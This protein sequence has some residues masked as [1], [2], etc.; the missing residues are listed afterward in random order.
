MDIIKD[1]KAR[2]ILKDVSNIE[3]FK[4][5]EKNSAI[6]IGFDPTATS[7]HLGNYIQIAILK[8]FESYGFKP[9]AILGGATG[10]IGDPSFKNAERKLLDEKAINLNK[11]KIKKQLEFF[12]LEVIDNY[13]WYKDMSI[14]DFLRNIGK[15]VNISYLLAKDSIKSRIEKGLSFTEFSYSLLQGY[16][17]LHLFRTKNIKIQFG[18]SDQW[19]NLT[20]GLE[21]IS[22]NVNKDHD[23]II[24]TGN[25]L[26][27]QNGNKI[28]KSQ[29]GGGLWIDKEMNPPFNLYQYF[30]NLDDAI[31]EKFYKWFSFKPL[32]E[33]DQIISEWKKASF[34]K[35]AQKMLAFEVVENIYSKNDAQKAVEITTALFENQEKLLDLSAKDIA[36]LTNSLPTYS[37]CQTSIKEVLLQN[38]I[39]SSNRELN[40][41]I[42]S[43]SISINSQKIT[44]SSNIINF[45]YDNKFALVKIGKRKYY[46]IKNEIS[47]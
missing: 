27:D 44:D 40:E 21:M 46:I 29:G 1:L 15:L 10:M 31:V 43:N 6:Y 34:K 33:I 45:Y 22:K 32:D 12:G 13:D 26:T 5:L 24:M 37:S 16:D 14:I 17:F 39:V 20:T 19:G 4:S 28:G 2:G 41:F 23:A 36:Q 42:N 30:I 35:T 25:L 8:R 9:Y 11:Q 7:L 38:K 3:K 47:Y 18:G